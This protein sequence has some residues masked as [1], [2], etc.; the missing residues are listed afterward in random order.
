MTI[1]IL[2][3]IVVLFLAVSFANKKIDTSRK[4][5]IL[6]KL[7]ELEIHIQS[8]DSSVRRDSVIKLD[9]LLAKSLQYYFNNTNTCGDNLKKS[10]SIFKRK[11]LDELWSVHKI[12]NDIVHNDYDIDQEEAINVFN[13]YKFSINKILK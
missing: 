4:V 3:L 5:E 9:N 10:S 6:N 13:I 1:V 7:K 2:L 8:L 11:E 12:R